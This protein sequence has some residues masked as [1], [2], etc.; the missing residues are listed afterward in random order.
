MDVQEGSLLAMMA[1]D[2]GL[3]PTSPAG[4]Q[5]RWADARDL[6]CPFHGLSFRCLNIYRFDVVLG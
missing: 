4:P 6:G 1:F 2:V 3:N 5:A